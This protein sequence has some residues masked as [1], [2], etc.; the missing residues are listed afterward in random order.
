MEAFTFGDAVPVLDGR[1]FMGFFQSLWNGKWYEPPISRDGL[2][3]ALG[4]NPHHQSAINM[5]AQRLAARFRPHPWLS[6][7]DFKRLALDSL[8][9]GECYVERRVSYRNHHRPQARPGAVTH[10]HDAI[11][12]VTA[13]NTGSPRHLVASPNPI[14]A[15]K[16]MGCRNTPPP[17]NRPF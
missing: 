4:A 9:F 11:P 1:D 7:P 2:A 15:R 17:C 16:S 8:V 3:K 12:P 14:S 5:K 13:P 10:G 6:R